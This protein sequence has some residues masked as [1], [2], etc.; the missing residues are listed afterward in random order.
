MQWDHNFPTSW[1]NSGYLRFSGRRPFGCSAGR[2]MAPIAQSGLFG[3]QK[4]CFSAPP[5]APRPA[6]RRSQH[7]KVVFFVFRHV[8]I[9]QIGCCLQKNWFWAKKTAFLAPKRTLSAIWGLITAHQ[10]V[11]WAPTS[12]PKLSRATSWCG[13]VMIPLSWVYLSPKIVV[14]WA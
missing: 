10:A 5:A 2:F 6:V 12:K 11:E 4:C 7:K 9:K 1:G 13:Y 8:G 14:A 3:G